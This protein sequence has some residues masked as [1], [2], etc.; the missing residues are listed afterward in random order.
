MVMTNTQSFLG[1]RDTSDDHLENIMDKYKHH[2]NITCIN[3]YI[4]NSEITFAF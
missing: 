3:K 1:N 2:P 4:T